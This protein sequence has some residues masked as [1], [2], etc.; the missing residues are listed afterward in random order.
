MN[1][2]AERRFNSVAAAAE[3]AADSAENVKQGSEHG[4]DVEQVPR[5]DFLVEF[6]VNSDC[7]DTAEKAAVEHHAADRVYHNVS[8]LVEPELADIL[9]RLDDEIEVGDTV[10]DMRADEYARADREKDQQEVVDVAA[11]A[12]DKVVAHKGAG[13]SSEHD[14]NSVG[15]DLPAEDVK[16]RKHSIT[17]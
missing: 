4:V 11:E 12:F 5:L 15:A 7:G 10:D 13:D 1:G 14:H 2:E 17:P 9:K 8:E 6:A 16:R 3:K